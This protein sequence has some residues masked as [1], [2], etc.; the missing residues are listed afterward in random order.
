MAIDWEKKA[1]DALKR[2]KVSESFDDD[3]VLNFGKYKGK[4]LSEV[5]ADYLLWLLTD[6]DLVEKMK[7][8]NYIT[9][10]LPTILQQDSAS[11]K[12]NKD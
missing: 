3:K 11:R 12:K 7:L 9:L 2:L 1:E 10:C 5:P 8:C 6:T 4:K